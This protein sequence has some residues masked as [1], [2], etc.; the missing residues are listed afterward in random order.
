MPEFF[1]ANFTHSPS[2]VAWCSSSQA[3]H[4]PRDANGMTGRSDLA[5]IAS[6]FRVPARATCRVADTARL[7]LKSTGPYRSFQVEPRFS[8]P[9][10]FRRSSGAGRAWK[11]LNNELVG[12]GRETMQ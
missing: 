5:V 12:V 10:S 2:E 3:S 8:E 6:P 4:A 9:V 1:F 11:P 7:C